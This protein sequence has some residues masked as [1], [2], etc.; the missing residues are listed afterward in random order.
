MLRETKKNFLID[1]AFFI[2]VAAIIYVV[3]K[4]LAVYLFPFVIGL[5]I[6]IFVQRPA[7]FISKHLKIKKGICAI[8]FVISNNNNKQ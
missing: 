8:I 6:T 3:F 2:T 4:F 7:E 1:L 5:V